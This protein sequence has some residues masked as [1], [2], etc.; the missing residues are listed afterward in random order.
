MERIFRTGGTTSDPKVSFYSRDELHRITRQLGDTLIH[1]GLQPGDRV[2]NL[3]YNGEL[4]MGFLIQL[5]AWL[6]TNVPYFQL[7]IS[8][9]VDIEAT[10]WP[11]REFKVT[12][13]MGMTTT[14]IWIAE[15]VI[16]LYSG[17]GLFSDQTALLAKA[18]PNVVVRPLMYGSVDGGLIAIP[19]HDADLESRAGAPVYVP[20][21]PNV[22]AEILRE[23]GKPITNEE[24]RG[25][26]HVTDLSRRLMPII[27]YPTGDVAEW[28][29]F[30]RKQFVLRGRDLIGFKI[31]PAS[32]DFRH[33]REIV[34]KTLGSDNIQG[35]QT[36][37]RRK[38]GKDELV[39]WIAGFGTNRAE[40]Y[41]NLDKALKTH[42]TQYASG[43][44]AGYINP[45]AVGWIDV[46]DLYHNPRTGKLRE[47]VDQRF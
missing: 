37:A 2:A 16:S 40:G 25:I 45:L 13:A 12:V 39:F 22:V 26:L 41:E 3:Y 46:K 28:V 27:R 20:N 34:V 43:L 11:L 15:Y 7:P 42:T 8:G 14:L 29:D 1:A 21:S 31:G 10:V 36:V 19:T 17:E 6:D 32:Y 23:G 5:L 44:A 35:F 4:Y 33:L 18:F 9:V 30:S 47:T 24:E 38:N